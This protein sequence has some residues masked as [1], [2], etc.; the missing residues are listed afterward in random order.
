MVE[1][2]SA[3]RLGLQL[4]TVREAVDAD[5]PGTLARVAAAGYTGVETMGTY[6]MPAAELARILD[7]HGLAWIGAFTGVPDPVDLDAFA[8]AGCRDIV[9][10][11]LPVD[12][13]SDADAI[14]RGAEY[15]GAAAAAAGDYGVN[16]GYHNHYWEFATID[17]VP[18]LQR[19]LDACDP[20]VFAELDVYW[21]QVAGVDPAAFVTAIGPRARRLHVK[22]GPAV[23]ADSAMVAVGEGNVDVSSVLR[24][25]SHAEWHVVELDHCATDMFTAVERSAL[26]LLDL[27]LTLGG[28]RTSI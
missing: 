2:D 9:V 28:P 20:R 3:P 19:L 25:A 21:A 5:L 14:A 23:D 7:D 4:Y 24:A 17:G 11:F 18:A 10:P 6:G 22:D 26:Y 1:P 13:F 8:R 27:G 16:V 12:G 15:L